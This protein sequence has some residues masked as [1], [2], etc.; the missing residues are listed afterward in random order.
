MTLKPNTLAAF[1][2]LAFSAMSGTLFA[3]QAAAKVTLDQAVEQVQQQTGGTVLS[4]EQRHV[5][6]MLQYRIKV[7]APDGHVS[8]VA[9]SSQG[10]SAQ[11]SS[12]TL[13][14]PADRGR[15]SKEKH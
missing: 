9:V 7:L 14:R 8:V 1:C 15:A 4:A 10:A 11:A 5:G 2:A 3:D 13:K 6:R 12:Q